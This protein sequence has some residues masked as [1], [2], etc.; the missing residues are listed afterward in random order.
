[1]DEAYRRLIEEPFRGFAEKVLTFLPNLFIAVAVLAAG[2]AVSFIV[3]Y[4]LQK[5]LAALGIDRHAEKSGILDL[6]KKGGIKWGVTHLVA[7]L[8]FWLMVMMSIV[9]SLATLNVPQSDRLLY[10]F[11]LYLPNVFAAVVEAFLGYMLSNF[12]AKATLVYAV[13]AGVRMAGVLSRAVGT[14]VM[15]LAVTVALE[16]LGIG[17]GTILVAFSVAFGGLVL[18]LAIAF[19]LGGKD[20]AREFMEKRMKEKKDEDKDEIS[21]I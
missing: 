12:L 5:L 3:R 18:S 20:I 7:R 19:G 21:H 2:L 16:Q 13:N 11:F 17:H 1:M 15:L 9:I 8:A 4:V 14:V 10:E 6:L